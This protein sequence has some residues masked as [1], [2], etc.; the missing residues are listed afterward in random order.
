[1]SHLPRYIITTMRKAPVIII[2][3][4]LTAVLAACSTKKNTSGTRFFHSMTARFN[5]LYNGDVAYQAGVQ[6]QEKGHQDDYTRLL[7]MTI[8]TN[9]ATAKIG[10]SNYETSITK[11]EKAIKL[12]SIKKRP[13]TKSGK[14]KTPKQK[15]YLQRKEFNPYLKN[16][17][18]MMGKAQFGKGDFIEAASTFNYIIRLYSTQPEV[19]SVAKAWL[20]R[21]YVAL[22]WPYD[23]EDVLN[24]MRFDTVS[25]KGARE[26]DA[27]T[28]AYY[29]ETHQYAQA[30]PLLK[31]TIKHTRSKWQRARL[32]YLT[33]QLYME[34]EDNSNAYKYYSKVIRSNPPY[35]LAFNARIAQ[36]EVAA[37]GQ[38][39]KMIKKL[40]RMAKSDKN[41]DYLDQVYYAIG[42]IYLSIG[43]TVRCTW[44]YEDGAEKSTRNGIAKAVLLLRLSQ[45][46][47]EMEKYIDAQRTYQQCIAILDKE[48]EEYDE[49]ERRSKI[50]DEA[51][52]HLSAIKLQDSL[53]ALA[54]M[55][56]KEYLAA[57][58][59][60]IEEL[61]K[62]EKEEAKKAA[63]AAAT[64]QTAANAAATQQAAGA[65]ATTTA[66]KGAWYFYNPTT[67]ASGKQ[68]FQR[69]WGKRAN[70]DNW[71]LS[72]KPASS[73]DE[74][75]EY[76]Y[77]EA[78]DS[79]DTT[80][81]ENDAEEQARLD[82]LQNDPHSRE[83]Y[84]AQIP[85]TE[86]QMEASN[87]LLSD[88]LYH[89]GVIAM[90]KIQNFPYALGLLQ[91]LLRDFPDYDPNSLADVYYHLFLLYGRLEDDAQAEY[92]RR[93]LIDTYPEDKMA[94]LLAN[95]NYEL[96]ASRG[97]HIEDSIYAAAYEAYKADRYDEVGRNYEY[98]TQNFPEGRHR[99]RMMF[100]QAMSLL[101]T[102]HH[103]EF[104]ALL[105][106]LVNTY[107]KEEVAEIA[108]SIVKGVQEG[109]L[110]SDSKF[111]SG[112]IWKRRR[113]NME[114]G[115][116]LE[117]DTLSAS[118]WSTFN[119]VLAYQKNTLDE[120]QLLYEIAN[121]NFTSYMVRNFEIEILDDGQISMMC[122]K[123][124]LSYDEVHAYAQ[125]LYSDERMA[126][127]LEGIRTLLIS[128]ENLQLIG[129]AFSFDEYKDFYDEEFAP[130]D[131][132]DDL[133]IDEPE[134]LEIRNYDDD[135][136]EEE[137][138]EEEEDDYDD[139]PYGF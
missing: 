110:L 109:R 65:A 119:F 125:R 76:D 53:Q 93:L 122:V 36:T 135:E 49:A 126:R 29:I 57:I 87:Q 62:K 136:P 10:T 35:E 32:K 47:W 85:F 54:K 45:L 63:M 73:G 86:E 74:D 9:E 80:M 124:F 43:D 81:D 42:N 108:S 104:L 55:P 24:K 123:G 99:A 129:V 46:Y 50:L 139:F 67:L 13:Q 116:S 39:R 97:K 105:Q 61:K 71:R 8:Q 37:Q 33:A 15:E 59:R 112:D 133:Q 3:L 17:W 127:K 41:K 128:E 12:H 16:A 114:D 56:E 101:Y 134:G 28:A 72:T 48:H 115:D 18:L 120:D 64:A 95:P 60:V 22:E 1:M 130:L 26:R 91:R 100:V 7:P 117:V 77:S 79:I 30:I 118:R 25:V 94:V 2:L 89:G 31:Q 68:E 96:I 113:I 5:T 75:E 138:S 102:H 34:T 90:E 27:T 88:G 21:C 132:P 4:S 51:E 111:S 70:E 58:D 52:P 38:A 11:C 103:K 107:G 83:Y 84:L 137:N 14:K 78:G 82:S 66:N 69:K 121:Y 106:E 92:Y 19:Y 44:A 131:V 23:A 98:H 40:Q 6:A 20:A